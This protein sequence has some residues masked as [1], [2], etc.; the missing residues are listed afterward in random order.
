MSKKFA[1]N[2]EDISSIG[3][4][5]LVA[6]GGAAITY[7]SEVILKMDFGSYTP[8]V[9]ALWSVVVNIV[10]KYLSGPVVS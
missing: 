9:V 3:K 5:L 10:R 1:L 8:L 4:G 6:C 2:R 7:L